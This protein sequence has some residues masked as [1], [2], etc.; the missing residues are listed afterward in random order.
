VRIRREQMKALRRGAIS[1]LARRL[2]ADL[3]EKLGELLVLLPG[4]AVKLAELQPN[5]IEAMVRVCL[6]R[7]LDHGFENEN[8][9][10]KFTTLCFLLGPKF[11]ELPAFQNVIDDHLTLLDRRLDE[12]YTRTTEKDWEEAALAYDRHRWGG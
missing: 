11:D 8:A 4:H 9:L 3:R 10:A 2:A 7:G 12:I 5:Q 1:D 6:E